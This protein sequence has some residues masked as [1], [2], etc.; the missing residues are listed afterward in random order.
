MTSQ[1]RQYC[2]QLLRRAKHGE[3]SACERLTREISRHFAYMLRGLYSVDPMCDR[4][5]LQAAFQL[6]IWQGIDK[7]DHRGDP[8]YHLAWRGRMAVTSMVR[9][10]KH[11]RHG[12]P[13]WVEE[14]GSERSVG[15]IPEGWD[16]PDTHEEADP[17]HL[18]LVQA[19]QEEARRQAIYL[20]NQVELTKRQQD[21]IEWL[22]TDPD[23]N[24]DGANLRLAQFMGCSPQMASKY[25][26]DV[27]TKLSGETKE[28][29]RPFPCPCGEAF[30]T[31]GALTQHKNGQSGHRRCQL[32]RS[33]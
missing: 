16:P 6:G 4:D 17:V 22:T 11:R 9:A 27:L 2:M 1:E 28:Q 12:T 5:D 18:L 19:Q 3:E 14:F 23:V 8:L 29:L 32:A 15:T 7:V 25:R 10:L 24:S 26:R 13:E 20:L 21:V 31:K 30:P 33:S